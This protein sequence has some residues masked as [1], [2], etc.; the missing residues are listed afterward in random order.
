MCSNVRKNPQIISADCFLHRYRLAFTDMSGVRQ[1]VCL[2]I[3]KNH[4]TRQ[5]MKLNWNPNKT[6]TSWLMKITCFENTKVNASSSLFVC[7]IE[8]SQSDRWLQTVSAT[9]ACAVLFQLTWSTASFTWGKTKGVQVL[10]SQRAS[11]RPKDFKRK[12]PASPKRKFESNSQYGSTLIHGGTM[13]YYDYVVPVCLS[14]F[15]KT[16]ALWLQSGHC[17]RLAFFWF[18]LFRRNL[19]FWRHLRHLPL[20]EMCAFLVYHFFWVFM[21][22]STS[23]DPQP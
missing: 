5:I 3:E 21:N 15:V 7:C 22:S 2:G 18:Q 14:A 13:M 23:R 12:G 16:R 8:V 11:Q 17:E 19:R 10:Q 4:G 20:C 9:V 1:E 6:W